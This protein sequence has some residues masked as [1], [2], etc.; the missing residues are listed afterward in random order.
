M[1]A[2]EL[3]AAEEQDMNNLA[4]VIEHVPDWESFYQRQHPAGREVATRRRHLRRVM[5]RAMERLTPT[6]PRRR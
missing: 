1:G 3:D 2:E 5:S 6:A 4:N